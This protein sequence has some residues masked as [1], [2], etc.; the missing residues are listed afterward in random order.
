M[1]PRVT[2]QKSAARHRSCGFD[3]A[4]LIR[5]SW[6]GTG[7]VDRTWISRTKTRLTKLFLSASTAAARVASYV[8]NINP[9]FIASGAD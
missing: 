8:N 3:S 4:P 5:G 6:A 1:K 9:T 7:A 2:G